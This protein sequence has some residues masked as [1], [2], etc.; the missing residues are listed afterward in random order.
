MLTWCFSHARDCQFTICRVLFMEILPSH[1]SDIAQ[2][3]A[4]NE[5][6]LRTTS[7]VFEEANLCARKA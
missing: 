6:N 5:A 4:T 1:I 3:S 2:Y 7:T